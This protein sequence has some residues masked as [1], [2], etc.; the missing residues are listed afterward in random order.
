MEEMARLFWPLARL[1]FSLEPLSGPCAGFTQAQMRILFALARLGPCTMSQLSE[2]MQVHK[3]S[4]SVVVEELVRAG[5]VERQRGQQDLRLVWVKLTAKGQRIV[6]QGP[7]QFQQR[8]RSSLQ[9]LTV[10]QQQRVKEALRTLS[11]IVGD[12]EERQ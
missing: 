1:A 4:A 9:R 5:L 10:E 3:S 12:L 7:D 6:S 11:G 2:E 8:L